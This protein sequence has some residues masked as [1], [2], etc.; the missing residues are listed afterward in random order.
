[1]YATGL[2]YMA[3][4]NA[5][6]FALDIFYLD[7]ILTLDRTFGECKNGINTFYNTTIFAEFEIQADKMHR[8][9]S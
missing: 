7:D 2:N 4:I 5:I 6:A 3:I 9:K 8:T 1:M